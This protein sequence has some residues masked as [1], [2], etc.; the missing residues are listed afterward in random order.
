[1]KFFFDKSPWRAHFSVIAFRGKL[2]EIT[3]KVK[4]TN[5]LG[6]HLRAAALFA[7]TSSRFKCEISVENHLS[8][9]DGKS[10]IALLTLAATC[11]TEL[12]ITFKGEDARDAF[13]AIENLFL[14]KFGEKE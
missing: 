4:I 5:R 9:A 6:L 3:N 2:M 8:R 10:I 7:R 1:V 13:S 12:T 11:G 14:N